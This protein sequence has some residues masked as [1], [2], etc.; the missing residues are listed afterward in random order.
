MP[1]PVTLQNVGDAYAQLCNT[2][3][4]TNSYGL[5]VQKEIAENAVSP[6]DLLNLLA[7]C[8]NLLSI[9]QATLG[10]TTLASAL[11]AYV[12]QQAGQPTL[13]VGAELTASMVALQ[14][15]IAAIVADYPKDSAGFMEDRTMGSNGVWG[16]ATFTAAQLPTT[17]AALV[18]WLTTIQ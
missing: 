5:M 3:V 2:A 11:V 16:W 6:P 14:A 17:P 10:N 18:A 4:N 15:L 1:L 13:D 9:V 12:Q 7:S 8:S